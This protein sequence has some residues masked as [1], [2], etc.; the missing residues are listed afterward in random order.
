MAGRHR[1]THGLGGAAHGADDAIVRGA[2]AEVTVQRL[3]DLA[4]ARP[5]IAIEQRLCRHDHAVAAEAAL[6]GLLLDESALER[7]QQ[8]IGA[9]TL[10][11]R[12]ADLRGTVTQTNTRRSR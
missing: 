8:V 4:L 10:T 5:G 11:G 6:T 7:M 2:P 3:L 12:D 1:G 9:Q